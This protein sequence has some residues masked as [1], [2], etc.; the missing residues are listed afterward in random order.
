[1][2]NRGSVVTVPLDF[3]TVTDDKKRAIAEAT[4]RALKDR[5]P[6]ISYEEY[7]KTLAK[8]QR[9]S[10]LEKRIEALELVASYARDVVDY[11]PSMSFKTIRIM[12]PKMASLKEALSLMK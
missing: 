3:S 4:E 6:Q 9:F 8:L 10:E 5:A 1:M 12:I 7:L 2:E 11:W